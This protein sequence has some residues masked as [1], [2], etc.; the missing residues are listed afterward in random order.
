MSSQ[1]LPTSPFFRLPLELREYI[2]E[3]VLGPKEVSLHQ[4]R[5]SLHSHLNRDELKSLSLRSL[6]VL[7]VCRPINIEASNFF[8]RTYSLH[9]H[10]DPFSGWLPDHIE[11]GKTCCKIRDLKPV[12]ERIGRVELSIELFDNFQHQSLTI[13]L[14]RWMKYIFN[15]RSNLG[16]LRTEITTHNTRLHLKHPSSMLEVLRQIRTAN[17]KC[18]IYSE[19]DPDTQSPPGPNKWAQSPFD[20]GTWMQSILDLEQH[21]GDK[22]LVDIEPLFASDVDEMQAL[23]AF[24]KKCGELKAGDRK[25]EPRGSVAPF[26]KGL[27]PRRRRL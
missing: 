20:L 12:L 5:D 19:K 24:L 7:A 11:L 23:D 26:I 27:W 18:V 15:S 13:Y 10:P 16:R 9:L 14:L 17:P 25:F 4:I 21:E 3:L 1:Q 6:A 2:Y 8:N 22:L